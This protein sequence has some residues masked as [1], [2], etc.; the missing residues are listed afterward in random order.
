MYVHFVEEN[1]REEKS[2]MH[3]LSLIFWTDIANTTTYEL[4]RTVREMRICSEGEIRDD[5]EKWS[6]VA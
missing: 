2:I 4:K 5:A 1:T 6:L 3:F